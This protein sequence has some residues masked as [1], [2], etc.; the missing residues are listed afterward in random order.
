MKLLRQYFFPEYENGNLVLQKDIWVWCPTARKENDMKYG[1][2]VITLHW[3]KK[4]N[5]YSCIFP[6]V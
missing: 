1:T 6:K 2:T 4:H 5:E 3:E